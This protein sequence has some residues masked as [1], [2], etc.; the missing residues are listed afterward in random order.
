MREKTMK[1][2]DATLG[3]DSTDLESPPP[4]EE[5]T[6]PATSSSENVVAIQDN[7]SR[8]EHQNEDYHYARNT[9]KNLISDGQKIV[10]E[11]MEEITEEGSNPTPRHF[12]VAST[13]MKN[14]SEISKD[15]VNLQKEMNEVEKGSSQSAETINNVQNNYNIRTTKEIIEE[16][17]E[18][19]NSK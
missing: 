3:V 10:G 14:V 12:E 16:M 19:E 9:M 15:L 7:K 8:E 1:H 6:L 2:I 4:V 5:E 18:E 17:K 13:L 11:L